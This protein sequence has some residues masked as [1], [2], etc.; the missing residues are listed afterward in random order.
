[1]LQKS[2]RKF[3]PFYKAI[4]P[5]LAKPYLTWR[6][7]QHYRALQLCCLPGGM[8]L[9]WSR[10]CISSNFLL[11]LLNRLYLFL[12]HCITNFQG[13]TQGVSFFLFLP[14]TKLRKGEKKKKRNAALILVSRNKVSNVQTHRTE[15]ERGKFIDSWNA[16]FHS[17]KMLW[18]V[19][20]Y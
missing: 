15:W 6:W 20:S 8:H 7:L 10:R 11:S 3:P 4:S 19:T 5:H 16:I 17:F 12:K 1:M 14:P 18:L 2:V 13:T 9:K